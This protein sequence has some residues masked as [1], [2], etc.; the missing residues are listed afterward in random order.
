MSYRVVVTRIETVERKTKDWL[1]QYDIP[2]SDM[3]GRR[4]EGQ[5]AYV[6]TVKEVVDKTDIYDQTVNNLDL[7]AVI[8]AVNGL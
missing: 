1:K 7:A 3:G 2:E 8:K 6:E 5:Y 4:P